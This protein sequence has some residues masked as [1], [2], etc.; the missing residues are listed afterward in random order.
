M[1]VLFVRQFLLFFAGILLAGLLGVAQ[2]DNGYRPDGLALAA[3]GEFDAA[4]ALAQ[5]NGDDALEAR[6]L[7]EKLMTHLERKSDKSA[8]KDL[9]RLKTVSRRA[10]EANPDDVET[11]IMLATA[12]WL[13]ARE[14]G[15]L[16]G[17]HKGLPQESRRLLEHAVDIAP[18]NP[19]VKGQLGIW[20]LD[21]IRR[22]GEDGAKRL[23]ADETLGLS[24]WREALA[25]QPDDIVLAAH[26]AFV[27]LDMNP[28]LYS[29]EAVGVLKS[30]AARPPENRLEEAMIARVDQVLAAVDQQDDDTLDDLLTAW[31][32]K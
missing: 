17:Y 10:Q 24:L 2:A 13:D 32:G 27:L 19:R 22:G 7:I 3:Q 26:G 31:L 18:D 20:N 8:R 14:T 30:T 28:D 21:V 23:S 15:K 11:S 4:I 25:G 5:E 16:S 12:I 1:K 9:K 6:V 29:E